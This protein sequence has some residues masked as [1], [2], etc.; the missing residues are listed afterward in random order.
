MDPATW[1]TLVASATAEVQ[2]V[3][4]EAVDA[5]LKRLR[6]CVRGLRNLREEYLKIWDLYDP[7]HKPK[8]LLKSIK[9]LE[10]RIAKMVE[11]VHD[12][13]DLIA[14]FIE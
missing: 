8:R 4:E 3:E 13:Q 5:K 7:Q 11:R 10:Y 6:E 1:E 9:G 2:I 14:I 12:E